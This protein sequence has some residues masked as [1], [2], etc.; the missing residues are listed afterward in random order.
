MVDVRYRGDSVEKVFLGCRS[1]FSGA[2]DAFRAKRYEGPHRFIQNQS[3]TFVVALKSNAAKERSE[4]Q[5]SR[6]FPD[7]SIFDFCNTIGGEA[8]I[9]GHC[10]QV[11][12]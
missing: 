10:R 4:D 7:R 3:R 6:D 1:K 2:A 5:L 8:D 9:V 12:F 11:R